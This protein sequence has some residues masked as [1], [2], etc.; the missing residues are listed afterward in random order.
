M[1]EPFYEGSV[2]KLYAIPDDPDYMVTETTAGGSVFDVGTIFAIDGSDVARAVFRHVLF[3]NLSKPETWQEVREAV[4][5]A[6]GLD[7]KMKEILLDGTIDKL[8]SVGGVTHHCGMV[9]AKTGEVSHEGLPE[10]E[11][12][13]NIVRRFKIEKPDQ[14]KFLKHSFYDY[15]KFND[16]DRNVVPLECIVRF[17]I[18]SGSS[19]FRKYLK[20]SDSDKRKFEFELGAN[21]PLTAWEYL[22]TPIVDFTSKYEPEDRAVTKQEA[23]NMSGLDA[24]TFAEL[25]K[26]AILGGW[27]VRVMVEKMGLQLWDLKW[28]FARDGDDLVFV[29]TID[30]DSF[31]A[32]SILE[33]DGD[34]IV[35]HYNKQ[36]MR[37]YY[38][39]AHSDWLGAINE[40]KEQGRAEGVPFVEILRARQESGDAPKDPAVDEAFLAIQVDKMNL[41]KDCILSR[42]ESDEVAAA[43]EDC[44]K[45]EVDFYT[46][47]GHRDALKELNGL[48]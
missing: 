32:T 33:D 36:A 9:D 31:R 17:G 18:T 48:A 14:D 19:V 5:S 44:G 3:T 2:Q 16:L 37:D 10:N 12:A 22:T 38:K 26:L 43:L 7:P 25:G 41:I 15:S 24:E 23:H 35:I 13:L 29:D 4:N 34:R 42:R 47:N 1:N 21:G 20:L 11:S 40:A 8:T 6:E 45:R 27:A 46:G 30:T 28:E 39:I